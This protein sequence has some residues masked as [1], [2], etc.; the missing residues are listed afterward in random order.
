MRWA[1][2]FEGGIS[3]PDSTIER[4]KIAG[5]AAGNGNCVE[6]IS[7]RSVDDKDDDDDDDDQDMQEYVF[8]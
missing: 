1:S 4:G 8:S 5:R 3:D 7:S 2:G 6:R